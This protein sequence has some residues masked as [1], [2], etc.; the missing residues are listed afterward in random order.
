MSQLKEILKGM[1]NENIEF[2]EKRMKY[3]ENELRITE[4]DLE[5]KKEKQNIDDLKNKGDSLESLKRGY[6][7]SAE[8]NYEI[9]VEN[10]KKWRKEVEKTIKEEVSN[11]KSELY[12]NFEDK[13]K[14]AL[15]DNEEYLNGFSSNI[16]RIQ[17]DI[18]EN[19]YALDE[20]NK[21][22]SF[23]NDEINQKEDGCKAN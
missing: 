18:Q 4:L 14:K 5:I 21:K 11:K 12:A 10:T 9:E 7:D 3:V 19:S 23:A 6:I 13:K 2:S 1:M 17:Q 22:I 8:K 15:N 20:L 16:S